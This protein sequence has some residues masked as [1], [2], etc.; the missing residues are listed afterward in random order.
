MFGDLLGNVEQQQKALNEKLKSILI[1]VSIDDGAISIEMNAAQEV[2]N[3]KINPDIIDASDSEK[4][5]DLLTILVN[6]ALAKCEELKEIESQ[7]MIK[8]LMPSGLDGLT[9]MFG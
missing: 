7:K 6:N 3:F 8:E 4:L 2:L 9:N 5:E 1:N